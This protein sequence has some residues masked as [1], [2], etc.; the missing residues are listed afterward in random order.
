MK[1]LI[2]LGLMMALCLPSFSQ[3]G[4]NS[5]VSSTAPSFDPD[6]YEGFKMEKYWAV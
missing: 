3:R 6:I 4:K 2:L 1:K 5:T